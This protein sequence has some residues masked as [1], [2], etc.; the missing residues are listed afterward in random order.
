MR[1]ARPALTAL[2]IALLAACGSDESSPTRGAL[3]EPAS[4]VGTLPKA[5]LGGPCDVTVVGLNYTT[6]GAKS[7]EASNAS[8]GMLVPSGTDAACKGPFPIIAYSRGTEVSKP[9]TMASLTDGEMQGMAKVFAAWGYVVVATDY[10]GFAKSAYAF[11]PY[12]HA[13]SEA[14]AVIDS[15]RAARVHA[16][17]TALPLSGKLMLYGYSQGGHSSL[18]TQRAIETSPVVSGEMPI[19]AAGHGA[20]PGALGTS[21]RTGAE[22]AGGQFFVPFLITAWQKVYGDVY[23]TPSEIFKA[24]YDSYIENLLPSATDTYTTLV[25]SGKLPPTTYSAVMFQPTFVPSLQAGTSPVIRA[26]VRN[27]LVASGWN[28][29]SQTRFCAGSGDPTVPYATSQKLAIDKWGKQANVSS[30]DVD[31]EVQAAAAAQGLTPA[32]VL[33]AYHG[34]LAPVVCLTD[35]RAYFDARR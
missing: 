20:A 25:T 18:A 1:I 11:H 35:M 9:R 28:P 13:D 12:L 6:P 5:A 34:G 7:G 10:L 33:A 19:A 14:T 24:P 15:I 26:A 4:T 29:S 31:P 23:T 2:V 8:A 32:Q 16:A 21:L 30:R 27:D 22:I 17:N 3:L